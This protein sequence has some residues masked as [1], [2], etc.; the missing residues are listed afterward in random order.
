MKEL[1]E[2]IGQIVSEEVEK[3]YD[4]FGPFRSAHEGYALVLEEYEEATE[5]LELIKNRLA[6]L[7]ESVKI[8]QPSSGIAGGV[9]IHAEMLAVE[10][11]HVAVTAIRMARL[12][13]GA[14]AEGVKNKGE[15]SR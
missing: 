4:T 5:E 3:A 15:E 14:D 9:W 2:K 8:N 12:L 13:T 1:K 6:L 7:W 11:I 10:A